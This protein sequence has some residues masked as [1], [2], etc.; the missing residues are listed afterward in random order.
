MLG[1]LLLLALL[2]LKVTAII[3]YDRAVELQRVGDQSWPSGCRETT[4]FRPPD[5]ITRT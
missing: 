5:R 1:T 3:Q 2:A 4:P